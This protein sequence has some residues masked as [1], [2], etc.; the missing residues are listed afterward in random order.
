M[1]QFRCSSGE[2]IPLQDRCNG[3]N[4]CLDGSDEACGC[5]EY[6]TGNKEFKCNDNMCILFENKSPKC[7]G[8]AQCPDGSDELMCPGW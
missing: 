8:V 1:D 6:C 4:N 5:A 2:C 7:D 3:Q